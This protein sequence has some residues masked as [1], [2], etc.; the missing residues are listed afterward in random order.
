MTVCCIFPGREMVG[1]TLPGYP[2][3]IPTSGQGSYA[4]SAIAGMVAGSE[5]SGNAYGHTPYSSY[6]EAWRFPN[7]SLLSKSLCLWDGV[8]VQGWAKRCLKAGR[9]WV[10]WRSWGD[11]CYL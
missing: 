10:R 1:P 8:G 7:S 3:H 6:S 2:P 9:P 4:S 5:Y 11:W